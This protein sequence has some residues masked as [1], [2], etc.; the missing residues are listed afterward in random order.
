LAV[1]VDED[2][3]G[4]DV[5]YLLTEMLEFTACPHDVIEQVPDL[6]LEEVLAEA[7]AVGDLCLEYEF[8]VV[9]GELSEGGGTLA[10]PLEPHMPT[11]WKE[12]LSGISRTSLLSVSLIWFMARCHS[13]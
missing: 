4:V 7:V 2:V 8:V 9:I 11:P 12:Y 3:G 5:T 10:I 1:F 13:W 6:G